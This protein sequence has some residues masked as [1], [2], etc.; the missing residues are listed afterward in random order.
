MTISVSG[1]SFSGS[2]NADGI[3]LR[4]IKSG[5]HGRY[6]SSSGTVS[7]TIFSGDSMNI[8]FI[9]P[10]AETGG[11]TTFSGTATLS[12]NTINGK[13]IHRSTGEIIGSFTLTRE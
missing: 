4:W 3:E 13:F 12:D 10:I 2:A 9:F 11:T 7:G 5:E 8:T 1:D 6:V